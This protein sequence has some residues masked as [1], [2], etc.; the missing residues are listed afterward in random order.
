M[1]TR[2]QCASTLANRRIRFERDNQRIVFLGMMGTI[3]IGSG[4]IFNRV[5]MEDR[6]SLLQSRGFADLRSDFVI[7]GRYL[8]LWC[9]QLEHSTAQDEKILWANGDTASAWYR[10]TIDTDNI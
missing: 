5:D 4:L 10:A 7:D 1:S 3:A 6:E 8:E 2:K 9:N